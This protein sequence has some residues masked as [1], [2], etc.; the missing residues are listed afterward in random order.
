MGTWRGAGAGR[1]PAQ[2]WRPP[3]S[4]SQSARDRKQ[5]IKEAPR[6]APGARGEQVRSTF[7]GATKISRDTMRDMAERLSK[8]RRVN[9]IERKVEEDTR[10]LPASAALV[11]VMQT[12]TADPLMSGDVA[13]ARTEMPRVVDVH[14]GLKELLDARELEL[15]QK[16]VHGD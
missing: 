13:E 10:A 9:K 12:Y 15:L 7:V 8:P 2:G 6:I 11:R 14:D 16:V 5:R 1:E 3:Q 4:R